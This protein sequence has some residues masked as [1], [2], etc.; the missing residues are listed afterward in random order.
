MSL[1]VRLW[2]IT[3]AFSLGAILLYTQAA[4]PPLL[5]SPEWGISGI[6]ALLAGFLATRRQWPLIL[7]S[8]AGLML[9]LGWSGWQGQQSLDQQ[10]PPALE[11][12][13]QKV[14]GYVCD[15]PSPGSFGS[16]RFSFCVTRWEDAGVPESQ[17]PDRLRLAAY[18]ERARQPLPHRAVLTVVLKKPHGSVNPAGFRYETWLFRQGYGA[19]G[20]VR[21]VA[22]DSDGPC[23]VKC[24][25]HQWRAGVLQG[26]TERIGESQYF[27]L[28]LSLLTGHRGY[29]E[30]RHWDTLEATGTIHLVAISGLHLGLVATAAG[31]LVKLLLQWLAAERL[32]P[33]R[34]RQL[35]FLAVAVSST[36]YALVAGFTIP[37]RRALL[38]VIIAGWF[39][40]RAARPRAW[41]GW[42]FSLAVILLFDPRAPLDQGFWLSFLAVAVLITLFAGRLGGVGVVSGLV[43][44]Q[45]GIF[46]GLLPAL[47]WLEQPSPLTGL[48]ANLL[49]IPL[50]SFLVMPVLMIGGLGLLLAPAM[51]SW[52]ARGFDLVLGTLWWL[53]EK[54][55]GLPV[56][57][58]LPDPWQ[59]LAL[60]LLTLCLILVPHA[61]ARIAGALVVALWLYL[62]AISGAGQNLEVTTPE[63]H[64]WDVGQGLSVLM[65]SENRALLYDTGPEVPGRYSAVESVLLP[66]LK[67][68]GVGRIDTLVIS[69]GDSD[70]AGGLDALLTAMP[71]GRVISGQPRRIRERLAGHDRTVIDCRKVSEL[72]YPQTTV[73]VWRD[74]VAQESN[75][76]SCVLFLEMPGFTL[77]LPG[78]ITRGTERKL[79]RNLPL[80]DGAEPLVMLAPHHGSKT[81]SSPVLLE[82]L[83]PELTLFSAGYRH[84]FGHPHPDVVARY[85]RLGLETLNIACT[86]TITLSAPDGRLRVDLAR[87]T[88]RFWIRPPGPP[89]EPE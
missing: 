84:R 25:F 87:Q 34:I 26:V 72:D 23:G 39:L 48:L 42:L 44:A 89:C 52:I 33:A 29:L 74:A 58:L 80:S 3:A 47:V 32:G 19:T 18:G 71:V 37:T 12:Q 54:L 9:G 65:R 38:M 53:L 1:N 4:L 27:P 16:I 31:L 46:A 17:L 10:L 86:G 50:V 55:A 2:V 51:A 79:T 6:A 30:N 8:L 60:T 21:E 68:L 56:P 24:H 73:T 45:A 66:N 81:S 41:Q 57:A 40:T 20:T 15:V 43:L 14:R 49:A 13:L 28:A 63:V 69:H 64:V 62:Q 7:L 88:A 11:G 82:T 76:T 83:S 75:D 35:V 70:H 77:V 61:P 5:L 36:L 67:R 59:A 85:R 78:D 22:R